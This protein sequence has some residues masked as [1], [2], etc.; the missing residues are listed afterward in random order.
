MT[1][2]LKLTTASLLIILLTTAG[3]QHQHPLPA[4]IAAQNERAIDT[5]IAEG[6]TPEYCRDKLKRSEI[7]AVR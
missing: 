1:T 2:R 3:Y 7:L 6:N 5:C 4:D